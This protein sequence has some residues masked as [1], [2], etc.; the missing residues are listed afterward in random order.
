MAVKSVFTCENKPPYF[1][2]YYI[3]FDYNIGLSLSQKR[4]N[5]N[6]V[7]RI[8]N[9]TISNCQILEISSKSEDTNGVRLS[10]FNLRKYVPSEN[11]AISVE[12]IY[13]ASKIFEN[14]GPFTDL[15]LVDSKT[16]KKDERLINSGSIVGF[17][18][19][20]I[21]YPRM[22][23]WAFYNYIYMLALNENKELSKYLLNFIAFSD[24]EFTTE[25]INCQAAAAAQYVSLCKENKLDEALSNFEVYLQA[26]AN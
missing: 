2:K 6:S 5:I 7:H 11:R 23:K 8:F 4:E 20:G 22:P 1:K 25:S 17:T 14:G 18:Y 10:A 21:F 9:K 13:Q 3:E 24:I 12:C 16:A 26:C 15:L 19:E